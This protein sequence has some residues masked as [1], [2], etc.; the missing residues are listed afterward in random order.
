MGVKIALNVGLKYK[1]MEDVSIW[2]VL[3]VNTNFAGIVIKIGKG[4]MKV[5]VK[6]K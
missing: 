6:L 1:K 5:Y 4:M 2:L 3:I